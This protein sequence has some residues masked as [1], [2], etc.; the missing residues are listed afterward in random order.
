MCVCPADCDMK[1]M[2]HSLASRSH[3]GGG[4]NAK[5]GF[6]LRL[7]T[8]KPKMKSEEWKQHVPVLKWAADQAG[9]GHVLS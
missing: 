3:C 9:A 4:F 6:A 1:S 8:P 5:G 2:A 7:W